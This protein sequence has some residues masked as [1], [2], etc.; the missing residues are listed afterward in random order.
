MLARFPVPIFVK[1]P[2]TRPPSREVMGLAKGINFERG[3]GCVIG[4]DPIVGI[5][6]IEYV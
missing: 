1:T 4:E 5:S 6:T 2:F 3:R